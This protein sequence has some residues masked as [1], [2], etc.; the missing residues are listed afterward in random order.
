MVTG[1]SAG[2][3]TAVRT[4]H[5]FLSVFLRTVYVKAGSANN[6]KNYSKNNIINAS[7]HFFPFTDLDPL[8]QR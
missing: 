8:M 7:H 4:T 6:G 3:G 5:A 1:A 2:A